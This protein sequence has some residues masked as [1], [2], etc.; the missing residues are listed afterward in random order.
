MTI[1]AR[2][3]AQ[4]SEHCWCLPCVP[5][6]ALAYHDDHRGGLC[7]VCAS[8]ELDVRWR[9]RAEKRL[10]HLREASAARE[11]L[12]NAMSNAN[13]LITPVPEVLRHLAHAL[14]V[15]HP[16]WW[17]RS[18]RRR[19]RAVLRA[20]PGDLAGTALAERRGAGSDQT[21]RNAHLAPGHA[22]RDRRRYRHDRAGCDD[23][24]RAARAGPVAVPPQAAVDTSP[25]RF[26]IIDD[27]VHAMDL[28][29]GDG[30]ARVLAA[31]A[32]TRQVVM[33]SHDYRLAEAVRRLPERST[34]WEVQRRDL[35]AAAQVRAPIQSTVIQTTP[36]PWPAPMRCPMS[37]PGAGRRVL[38]QCAGSR[39]PQQGPRQPP[40]TGVSP[41]RPWRTL[42]PR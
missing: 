4:G 30:L 21:G 31:V 5:Q 24:D 37:S 2:L 17:P 10:V 33:F 27:P 1:P 18:T 23:P 22:G 35:S 42:L 15:V 9:Q 16:R 3:R 14:A 6:S 12:N 11:A 36:N 25:F 8:G 38:P 39:S 32:K 19:H 26:L 7:P 34:T 28:A 41:M 29:K 40:R 13:R 20:F